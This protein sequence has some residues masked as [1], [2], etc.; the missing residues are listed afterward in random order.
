MQCTSLRSHNTQASAMAQQGLL[1][2]DWP[3]WAR[4]YKGWRPPGCAFCSPLH[5]KSLRGCMAHKY[6]AWHM[7]VG[8][9][10]PA[11]PTQSNFVVTTGQ[12]LVKYNKDHS[13]ARRPHWGHGGGVASCSVQV[14]HPVTAPCRLQPIA[15]T[16]QTTASAGNS[17]STRASAARKAWPRLVLQGGP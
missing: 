1:Q 8:S 4:P 12:P 15:I 5:P 14:T 16:S 13:T 17:Y 3:K 10:P 6:H 9:T 11:M 7:P 2:P